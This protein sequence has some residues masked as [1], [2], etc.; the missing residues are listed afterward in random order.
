MRLVS[1]DG[2]FGRVEGSQVIPMGSDILDYLANGAAID[3]PLVPLIEVR[4]RAPVPKPGKIIAVGFN[5]REHQAETGMKPASE[6]ALF[7]KY[8]NSVIGPAEVIRLPRATDEPDYEAEFAVVIGRTASDVD[9]RHALE[10]VAGYMCCNDVTARDLI[11]SNPQWQ[12]GK[13][14][15][16][17]L[18]CGPWLISNDEIP[19]PQTLG[20]RCLLNGEVMQNSSTKYMIWSVADLIS[21]ISQTCTLEPGDIIATGTPS[22]VG[23]A[24]KPQRFLHH[25][26][27]VLVE[28]D[29]IGR[30]VNSVKGSTS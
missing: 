1:F 6:P 18:P 29:R 22:G 14:I 23:A 3:E 10:Y 2:G 9:A 24:R 12:R 27:E 30:L 21:F 7:A 28:I 11:R 26:D 25:G 19:N 17:F 4:L 13:A 15:D 5:Y 16:S 8:A 20:I